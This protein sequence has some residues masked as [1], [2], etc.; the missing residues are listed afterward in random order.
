MFLAS[1]G[2]DVG[3]FNNSASQAD[4]TVDVPRDGTYRFQVI[5]ATPGK[6]GRHAL[7]VDGVSAATVQYTA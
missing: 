5:G 2:R 1:H 6:P 7:F 4:W 3:S